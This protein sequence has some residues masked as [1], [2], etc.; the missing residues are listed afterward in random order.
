VPRREALSEKSI[1]EE[2]VGLVIN[3]RNRSPVRQ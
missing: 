3:D 1:A 2:N